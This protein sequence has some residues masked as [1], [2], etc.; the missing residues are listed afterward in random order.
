MVWTK[1]AQSSTTD[2]FQP[3]FIFTATV[4]APAPAAG[5]GAAQPGR[6][7]LRRFH[8]RQILPQQPGAVAAAVA[9][10]A[11][12]MRPAITSRPPQRAR[13]GARGMCAAG[14]AVVL[15]AS[16]PPPG[17][18]PQPAPAAR[19]VPA[20]AHTGPQG[21]PGSGIASAIV[22][23]LGQ[24]ARPQPFV[25]RS[26]PPR[27]ARTGPAGL[28]GD[29]I[30]SAIVTPLGSPPVP[31][32]RP[33]TA[34]RVP[35]RAQ[36]G[37]SG[38]NAGGIASQ[39]VTPRGTPGPSWRPQP[40]RPA[41]AR[42]LWRAIA[43]PQPPAVTTVTA[44]QHAPPPPRSPAPRR[45]L[46]RGYGSPVVTPLGTPTARR[47][48]F[49][50]PGRRSRAA[51]GHGQVAGGIAGPQAVAP[52]AP[53]AYQHP[54][55]QPRS[56]APRRALW[57]GL[58]VP[59][60][61]PAPGPAWR[62]L[63]RSPAPRR[64]LWHGGTGPQPVTAAAPAAPRQPRQ[65]RPAPPRRALWHGLASRIVTP[66]GIPSRKPPPP[67]NTPR[68][69]QRGL[70]RRG[71]GPQP[72]PPSGLLAGVTAGPPASR[73][74]AT[75]LPASRWQP[76]PPA[77]RWQA[78]SLPASRY[79][80]GNPASRWQAGPPV[81]GRYSMRIVTGSVEYV[82]FPIAGPPGVDVTTF[83]VEVA[84]V[85][86]AHG[87]PPPG[88]PAWTAGSWLGGLAS[89]LVDETVL[90]NGDYVVFGRLTASPE[91]PVVR[92]GRVRLGPAS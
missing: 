73:W 67:A 45:V 25:F 3:T 42:G 28:P 84:V 61:R 72:P 15:A 77:S 29:G 5:A 53:Q 46:W 37:P 27:R 21:R 35:D 52:I 79:D 59:A 87:E 92:A 24:A 85:T 9:V 26:P 78:T 86:E 64:A 16:A 48:V 55:R 89:L 11:P 63:P 33:F 14:V 90:G 75:S 76:R 43:G 51:I 49:I 47:P 12:L 58:A 6:T 17:I 81:K 40:R 1:R 41:P 32:W 23:P 30:A 82:Q 54:P 31:P 71:A 66:L 70:W 44:Y 2:N 50:A 62:P 60:P 34:R 19:R 18:H 83:P 39:T 68:K 74:Q 56:S 91:K 22:T 88:D 4:P 80:A 8:H 10:P 38:R 13:V 20:R 7:W 57:R 69:R 36:L 65:P